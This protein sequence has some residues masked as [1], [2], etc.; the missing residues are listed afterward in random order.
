MPDPSQL[1]PNEKPPK[2]KKK[3][4]IHTM[5]SD[6]GEYLKKKR[7]LAAIMT[8]G[9]RMQRPPS[10]SGQQRRF[11]MPTQS[12][13]IGVALLLVLI[14]G[15]TFFFFQ[16]FRGGIGEKEMR[17][18]DAPPTAPKPFFRVDRSVSLAADT[19]KDDAFRKEF[20]T[21]IRKRNNI[22]TITHVLLEVTD[23][24]NAR[25]ATLRDIFYF[26]GVTPPTGFYDSITDPAM[27]FIYHNE[28]GNYVG[29]ATE[30]RDRDRALGRMLSWES[31][32]A[33]DTQSFFFE[34][35]PNIIDPVFSD[36]TYKNIDYRFPKNPNENDAGIAYAIF[37]AKNY[38]LIT[39]NTE[40]LKEIITRLFNTR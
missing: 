26:F 21:L 24:P 38:L 31:S 32:L 19:A 6:V 22:G 4:I 9:I 29:V 25:F 33:F 5:E 7:T 40:T 18:D 30:V 12:W 35:R 23:G 39:T 8:E 13:I 11:S 20:L 34:E 28:N 37:P 3:P 27:L 16:I 17:D 2:Q 10:I 1:Q 15:G 36:Y 14:G